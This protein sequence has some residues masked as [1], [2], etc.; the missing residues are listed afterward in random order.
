MAF[1]KFTNQ[2]TLLFKEVCMRNAISLIL[3][4]LLCLAVPVLAQDG[5]VIKG[6]IA[7]ENGEP[8]QGANV[9]VK[10]T[11]IGATGDIGSATDLEGNYEFTVPAKFANGQEVDLYCTFASYKQGTATITLRTGTITQDFQ[12]ELDI[13]KLDEIIVAGVVGDTPKKKM[14][15]TVEKVSQDV[16]KH[17]PSAS[18]GTAI[19]GKVS[20]A[21]V[22]AASGRPGSDTDMRLRG[23]N[24]ITRGNGPLVIV[25]G[26]ILGDNNFADLDGLDILDIQLVKGAAAS[27]MYGSRAANGVMQITTSRGTGLAINSTKVSFRSE[28]GF[29]TMSQYD[30]PIAQHHYNKTDG[31]TWLDNDG[32]AIPANLIAEGNRAI[33][34][35]SWTEQSNKIAFQDND[36]FETLYDQIDRFFDPGQTLTNSA[37]IGQNLGKTNWRASFVDR[38]EAGIVADM[39][40]YNRRNVRLN[41]DHEVFTGLDFSMS[42][43]YSQ[44]KREQQEAFYGLMFMSPNVDLLRPNDDGTPFHA[45]P[46][47]TS[48]EDNPIYRLHNFE[49]T[50]RRNRV[51]GSFNMRYAP[52]SYFNVEGNFSYD[53]VDA[54]RT[55]Y[56]PVGYLTVE[57][58]ETGGGDGNYRKN[59]DLDQALNSSITA[60]ANYAF[61]D[62]NTRWKARYLYEST[63]ENGF[64]INGSTLAVNQVRDMATV[65]GDKTI[66]SY[67]R[68]VISHGFF[69][70]TGWDYKDKYIADYLMRWDG[71][72]LFGPDERWNNYFRASMAYRLSE[73]SWFPMADKFNNFKLRYSIGTAGNRPSFDAQ[74]EVYDVSQGSVSKLTLGN[75]ALK[76]EYATE[77]E[78][79]IDFGMMDKLNVE[80][81]YA[82]T[83]TEDQIL[84]V[85]LPGFYGF[86]RQY[87]NAGTMKSTTYEG[88]ISYQLFQSRD[89]SWNT[90]L[91]ADRTRS[92]IEEFNLPGYKEDAGSSWNAFYIRDNED[93]GMMY[94]KNWAESISEL[95]TE[96]QQYSDQFQVN[97]DGL[98]VY[99]GTGN[100]Y[101]DGI[102]KQL[103]GNDPVLLGEG[104]DAEQNF[105][106][107]MPIEIYNEDGVNFHRMGRTTPDFSW[108]F[109]NDIRWKG[110]TA[111]VL[112]DAQMGGM[113]YNGTA[114]WA[115]REWQNKK[116]DQAGRAEGLKKPT[117]YYEMLYATNSANEW[118]A[119]EVSFVKLREISL[120]YAFN[121]SQIVSGLGETFGGWL[122]RVTVGLIGK[123][124]FSFDNYSGFD[125][126]TGGGTTF[127]VDDFNY[128]HNRQ[129]TGFIEIEF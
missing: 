2:S 107:G 4:L 71:S 116:N 122:D 60:N 89:F 79:G 55:R 82:T 16:L 46:D 47:P 15:F 44:S 49:D 128:P 114:Q 91:V 42:G 63:V 105:E 27:S 111:Y 51:M 65:S 8:M 117:W 127:R 13:L 102:S 70:I 124:L 67:Q 95:P 35:E 3:V 129:F 39:D 103:W 9:Y 38:T 53:R 40:G 73:E 84:R 97:D 30:N 5:A 78:M 34:Y 54:V 19:S 98:L 1:G 17:A 32:V 87:Q 14:A 66:N 96:L 76:P 45:A 61:M 99:V 20:A 109:S 112:L 120:R 23:S 29:N 12:M 59:T 110:L 25:D 57:N 7:D 58:Y 10:G 100:T 28:M 41:L 21:K 104:T 80:L 62:F 64:S 24:S 50:A 108:A 33:D 86:E 48:L 123:N 43:Y 6:K 125:P 36:F 85:P 121:K 94:G 18:M 22:N 52:Y 72:S 106:W 126:E 75:T 115:Y 26:V 93:Y 37:T 56:T 83:R 119:E 74:Y 68:D 90:R 101:Q 92:R 88:S 118:F 77:Q 69:F 81:T 31:T 11:E 113:V